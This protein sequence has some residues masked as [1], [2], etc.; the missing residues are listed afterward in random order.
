MPSTATTMRAKM[1]VQSVKGYGEP[2]TQETLS[3]MAVT[4]TDPFG[5]DRERSTARTDV[6][7]RDATV[8]KGAHFSPDRQ[9]RVHAVSRLGE[10]VEHADAGGDRAQPEY[11]RRDDDDPTI[12]RCIGFAKREGAGV[13]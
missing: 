5:P 6:P 3:L 1:L 7:S 10:L 12:R 8:H 11:R 13:S 4:G 2:V 9:Y